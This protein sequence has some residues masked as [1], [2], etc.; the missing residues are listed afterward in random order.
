MPRLIE[1]DRCPHCALELPE[2]KPRVCPG[3][4]GSLQQRFL[5]LG[6]LSSAPLFLLG[7]GALCLAEH[8]LRS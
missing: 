5:R 4:G 3:C 1:A 2:Q 8:L 6:C 7:L